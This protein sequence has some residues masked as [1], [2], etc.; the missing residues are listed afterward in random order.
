LPKKYPY[1]A[2]TITTAQAVKLIADVI[3]PNEVTGPADD[4]KK[5]R[6]R[7]RMRI[8]EGR[9]KG[10]VL[11]TDTLDAA[12]FFKWAVRQ[13]GWTELSKIKGLPIAVS[14]F[15]A[16]GFCTTKHGTPT[17]VVIPSDPEEI[18]HLAIENIRLTQENEQLRSTVTKQESEL[19]EFRKRTARVS[20]KASEAGKQGGR[21]NAK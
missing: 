20:A 21:G 8:S 19:A 16:T 13:K 2:S 14:V 6:N 4:R 12:E 5:V 15:Q 11:Q 7:V 17:A 1:L 3:Y 9:K 18:Q 10:D